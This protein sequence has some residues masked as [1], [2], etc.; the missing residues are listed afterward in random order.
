MASRL[1]PQWPW[2]PHVRHGP[3]E[4][5]GA[6]S[7]LDEFSD[8]RRWP[9]TRELV[10]SATLM[11]GARYRKLIVN[12]LQAAELYGT[13]AT[14]T[15]EG[16]DRWHP[17][18]GRWVRALARDFGLP[19]DLCHCNV[20]VSPRGAGVPRHFDAHHVAIVHVIGSKIWSIAPNRRIAHPAENF[21]AAEALERSVTR[22]RRDRISPKMP[23]S[24]VRIRMRPGSAFFL[25]AGYWHATRAME[26]SLS[27]TFGL[28]APRLFELLRDEIVARLEPVP[29]W[30]EPA[31]GAAGTAKQRR[32]STERLGLLMKR[33]TADLG[34]LNADDVLR[35]A[36][37]RTKRP[38]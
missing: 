38:R 11:A 31:W 8:F 22:G 10:I 4:R 28:R 7:N 13:G 33:W 36:A 26:A 2:R 25:P 9:K 14:L 24:S 3:I 15:F 18:L 19:A 23:R 16:V 21:V 5:L 6:L 30:R 20:Y 1:D 32:A 29:E 37:G 35:R 12:P 17:A 27:I 34:E